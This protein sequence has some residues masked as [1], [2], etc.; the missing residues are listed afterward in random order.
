MNN[1]H[2]FFHYIYFRVFVIFC[3]N[4]INPFKY[5]YDKKGMCY[6]KKTLNSIVYNY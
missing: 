4:S 6:K 3:L 1:I 2:D 5:E